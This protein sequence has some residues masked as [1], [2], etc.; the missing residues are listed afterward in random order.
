MVHSTF[1]AWL[2]VVHGAFMAWLAVVHSGMAGDRG[3]GLV[4]I[5]AIYHPWFS[6]C[7]RKG[8]RRLGMGNEPCYA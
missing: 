2:A 4:M 7:P 5:G 1:V 6:S 8:S 3:S